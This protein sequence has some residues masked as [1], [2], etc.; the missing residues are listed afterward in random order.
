MQ[1]N[2]ISKIIKQVALISQL[3]D[4]IFLAKLQLM[5]QSIDE[6]CLIKK[7]KNV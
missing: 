2:N 3:V 6:I 1:S 5:P 7:T 4:G